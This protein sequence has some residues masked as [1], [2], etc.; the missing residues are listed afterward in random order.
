LNED[1][2]VGPL[3]HK[4]KEYLISRIESGEFNSQEQ[5]PPEG[6]LCE[7][8]NVSRITIR[9][10][11]DE[12]VKMGMLV[13]K[14]GKGTFVNQ[15][16]INFFSIDLISFAERMERQGFKV[17]TKLLGME[18][19]VPTT[20]VA[21]ALGI[22]EGDKVLKIDRIR[23]IENDPISIETNYIPRKM[24]GDNGLSEQLHAHLRGGNSL[25][26]FLNKNI[27]VNITRA[28]QV[29]EPIILE[30]EEQGMLDC[31]G[32]MAG[33]LIYRTTYSGTTPIEF[34]KV[35]HRGDRCKFEM[36]LEK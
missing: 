11:I 24:L 6:Q 23:S 18:E 3:Y 26:L 10:A 12:L 29:F 2:N 17:T 35:I 31:E 4:V 22:N 16:K 30:E 9:R 5:I 27:G 15:P 28:H 19:I 32:N 33:L 34:V 20:K 1:F 21:K 36:E 7:E 25:Y 14:Q 13:K 8:Y